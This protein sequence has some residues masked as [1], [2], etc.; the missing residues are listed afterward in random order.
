MR[1]VQYEYARGR[2]LAFT[3]RD[4]RVFKGGKRVLDMPGSQDAC[5]PRLA[6]FQSQDSGK[7]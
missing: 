3:Q 4:F 6:L 5:V 2:D 1:I 7:I